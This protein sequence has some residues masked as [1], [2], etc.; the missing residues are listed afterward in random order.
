MTVLTGKL[1]AVMGWNEE[2]LEVQV[3][4]ERVHSEWETEKF[5]FDV[6]EILC[7]Q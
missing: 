7:F 4:L 6:K 2:S 1:E 3:W 5:D